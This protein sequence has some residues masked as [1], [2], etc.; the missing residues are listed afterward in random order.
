MNFYIAD[1]H[2][3][4]DAIV[5]GDGSKILLYKIAQNSYIYTQ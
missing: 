5:S 3:G 4:G 1:T 2:F